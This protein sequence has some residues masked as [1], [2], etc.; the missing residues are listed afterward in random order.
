MT[1]TKHAFKVWIGDHWCRTS[2]VYA[3]STFDE[4]MELV[5]WRLPYSMKVYHYEHEAHPIWLNLPIFDLDVAELFSCRAD[6]Q[7]RIL[8][9][10]EESPKTIVNRVGNHC[11]IETE[12]EYHR[13]YEFDPARCW[14]IAKYEVVP[15]P[16]RIAK[17]FT[18]TLHRHNVA[19]PGHKFS[20]GL[21]SGG[22][23]VGVVIAS[24]PKARAR[25]DGK[26]L[27]INRCTVKEGYKNACS[28]L[29]GHAVRAGREMGYTKFISYTL[30][31]ESGSSLLAVGFEN[32]GKTRK[33]PNGWNHPSRPREIPSRYPTGEKNIWMKDYA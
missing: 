19:P 12:D 1:T 28:K 2:S 30:P 31:E 11:L 25:C 6:D 16:F 27:E 33:A 15:L 18:N 4:V 24:E 8:V 17:D 20:I 29:Y 10:H 32:I 5:G 23:L 7:R 26:T 14:Y 9:K 3:D 13:F 22:E 21:R